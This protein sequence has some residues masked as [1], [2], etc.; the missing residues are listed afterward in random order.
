[1][2]ESEKINEYCTRV[3]N[4]VN[5][6]RNHSDTISNQQVVEKIVISVKE[7][8]VYIVAITKETK[9]L[10]KLSIEE[11]VGSFC[12]HEKRRFFHED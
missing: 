12:A 2:I 3:M 1:M 4:I 11:L 8:Y 9:D 5:E 10:S 6:I 7:K